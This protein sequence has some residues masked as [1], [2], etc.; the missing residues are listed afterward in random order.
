MYFFGTCDIKR[1]E[2]HF[3]KCTFITLIFAN[4]FNSTCEAEVKANVFPI[5]KN[6]R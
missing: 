3:K 1:A 5:S 6:F 2:V 4:V